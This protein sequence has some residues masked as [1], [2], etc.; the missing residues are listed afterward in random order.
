MKTDAVFKC[1]GGF[2]SSVFM[3]VDFICDIL[4]KYCF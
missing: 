3:E 4:I 1:C 2:V